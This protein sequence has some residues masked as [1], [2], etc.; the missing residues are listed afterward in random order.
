MHQKAQ[1]NITMEQL[2]LT[3]AQQIFSSAN[4]NP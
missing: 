4:Y 3:P 2:L 1:A